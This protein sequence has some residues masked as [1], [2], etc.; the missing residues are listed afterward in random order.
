MHIY[1]YIFELA[2]AG[3]QPWTPSLVRGPLVRPQ[4]WS[5]ET[6][7]LAKLLGSLMTSI[8]SH[9]KET[10]VIM[11]NAV[12][13]PKH[14]KRKW[15]CFMFISSKTYFL[16]QPQYVAL[17]NKQGDARAMPLIIHHD[18]SEAGTEPFRWMDGWMDGWIDGWMD[19]WMDGWIR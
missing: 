5:A 2:W 10:S 14:R 9:G 11:F 17:V 7:S 6:K 12:S 16:L 19:G 15:V 18:C 3:A 8:E 1:I 4:W 13:W